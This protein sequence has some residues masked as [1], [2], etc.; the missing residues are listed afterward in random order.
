MSGLEPTTIV[1]GSTNSKR[2]K[3]G[4]TCRRS[5]DHTRSGDV[6]PPAKFEILTMKRN[7]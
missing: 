5:H 1:H 6:S 4:D 3:M 2:L 7:C